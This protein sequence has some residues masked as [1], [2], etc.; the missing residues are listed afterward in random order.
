M[1]GDLWS[2]ADIV[3]IYTRWHAFDDGVLMKLSGPGYQGDSW[4]PAMVA[5]AGFRYP[6]AM[7]VTASCSYVRPLEGDDE[8]LAPT[9]P[10][11]W[12]GTN[13][14]AQGQLLHATSG[15][16]AGRGAAVAGRRGGRRLCWEQRR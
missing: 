2:D 15:D 4:T 10:C 11:R 3:D 1:P 6:L 16:G 8:K 13:G 14:L 9:F 5:E 7:T 12:D